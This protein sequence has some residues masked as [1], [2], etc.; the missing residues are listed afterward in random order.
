MKYH[1]LFTF[2]ALALAVGAI[3]APAGDEPDKRTQMMEAFEKLAK[4]YKKAGPEGT[5]AGR[6]VRPVD[7]PEGKLSSIVQVAARRY[8]PATKQGVGDYFSLT[9]HRWGK[10]EKFVLCFKSAAPV[11]FFLFNVNT[12]ADGKRSYEIVV[13]NEREAEK[14]I[15]PGVIY[16]F[17]TGLETEEHGDDEEVQ[18]VFAEPG[19]LANPG[20]DINVFHRKAKDM[21]DRLLRGNSRYGLT[22]V[23]PVKEASKSFDEVAALAGK[24]TANGVLRMTLKKR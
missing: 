10:T 1:C 5:L 21:A 7:T 12:G 6:R 8:D 3:P 24:D 4:E 20:G 16:E 23:R 19:K 13:P 15:S 17:Q 18:F 2:G 11:K 14:E 9:E 22:L